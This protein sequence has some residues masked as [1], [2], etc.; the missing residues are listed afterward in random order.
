MFQSLSRRYQALKEQERDM[1]RPGHVGW[2]FLPAF[3]HTTQISRL[4]F[5]F[6]TIVR[7]C[8][9]HPREEHQAL[10]PEIVELICDYA[11]EYVYEPI[12]VDRANVH[13]TC[14]HMIPRDPNETP[15]HGLYSDI[16]VFSDLVF[17]LIFSPINVYTK[18]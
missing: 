18:E 6:R 14:R 11:D 1:N 8:F 5:Y 3:K 4:S 13:P 9:V 2:Y 17:L 12:P 16:D 10:P 7:T 15:T